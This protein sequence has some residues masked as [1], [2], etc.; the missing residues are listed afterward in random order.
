M[1]GVPA[2]GATAKTGKRNSLHRKKLRTETK[3][4]KAGR[5]HWPKLACITSL[6]QGKLARSRQRPSL[7]PF[8]IS[9]FSYPFEGLHTLIDV[10]HFWGLILLQVSN[11]RVKECGRG[12]NKANG[13]YTT[14]T[15]LLIRGVYLHSRQMCVLLSLI[16]AAN[17]Q[18]WPR[19]KITQKQCA[20]HLPNEKPTQV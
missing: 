14:G 20:M 17:N 3:A 1:V 4:C 19:C 5:I 8:P 13:T 16:Q 10:V 6:G 15:A 12:L 18:T 11:N 7:F 9:C 2:S